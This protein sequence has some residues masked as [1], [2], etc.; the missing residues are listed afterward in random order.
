MFARRDGKRHRV[1]DVY[2]LSSRNVRRRSRRVVLHPV[3]RRTSPTRLWRNGMYGVCSWKRCGSRVCDVYALPRG[4]VHV[5][6]ES[7]GVRRL[8]TWHVPESNRPI[9]MRRLSARDG[10]SNRRRLQRQRVHAV[11]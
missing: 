6:G 8:L 10:E 3:R 5:D 11:R 4:D 9:G 2:S 7:R 1:S